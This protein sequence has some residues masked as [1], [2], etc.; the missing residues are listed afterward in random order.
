M[1][2]SGGALT[3]GCSPVTFFVFMGRA[4]VATQEAERLA[5][6]PVAAPDDHDVWVGRGERNSDNPPISEPDIQA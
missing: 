6:D 4:G 2:R 3:S 1:M 5:I